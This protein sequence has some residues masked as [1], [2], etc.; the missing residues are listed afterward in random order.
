MLVSPPGC[1]GHHRESALGQGFD[2]FDHA[3]G[4][5]VHGLVEAGKDLHTVVANFDLGGSITARAGH[6]HGRS[7]HRAQQARRAQAV[8]AGFLGGMVLAQRPRRG[9]A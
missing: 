1:A 5:G 4:D 9:H 6:G 7:A 3:G 2:P 8:R